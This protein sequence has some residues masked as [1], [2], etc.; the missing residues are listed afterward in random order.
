MRKLFSALAVVLVVA[1]AFTITASAN[2]DTEYPL[3]SDGKYLITCTSDKIVAGDMV[4]MVVIGAADPNYKVIDQNTIRYI[5]QTTAGTNGSISF[6]SFKPMDLKTDETMYLVYIGGGELQEATKIGKLAS[7]SEDPTPTTYD[8]IF[9][10]DGA[11][12]AKITK[13]VGETLAFADFPDVPA[14]TGYTGVWS[15]TTDITSATTV[16]AV[17][18]AETPATYDVIFM[19]DGAQVAKIT[20]NVGETLAFA[21]FPDVPAKTGYTG[22]WNVTTDITS[23]TTVTAVYTEDSI[24]DDDDEPT[25][26]KGDVDGNGRLSPND[27]TMI[28]RKIAGHDVTLK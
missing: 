8:V 19:A 12:V 27:S 26:V 25:T 11:Q 3:G 23:A 22:V 17:Y 7:A 5:D 15:V 24:G 2:T 20:K 18:T 28:L 16:T 6:P 13:N 4:G 10:A 14:K 9:M 1:M 21:D